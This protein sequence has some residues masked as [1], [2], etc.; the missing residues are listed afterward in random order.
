MRRFSFHRRGDVFYV[1][2]F[3]DATGRFGTAK[4]TGATNRDEAMIVAARWMTEGVP[5]GRRRTARPA[6][7][8]FTVEAILRAIKAPA[9]GDADAAL[10]LA[11][12]ES[13]GFVDK[14]ARRDSPAAVLVADF[15]R[16]FWDEDKSP[17]LREERARGRTITLRH[18]REMGRIVE[19]YWSDPFKGKRLGDLRKADIRGA[20][21]ALSEKGLAPGTI[22]KAFACLS[23]ALRWA[24]ESDV[25]EENPAQG[26]RKIVGK[27]KERGILE[28]EELRDLFALD[29]PDVRAKAAF[30]LAATTGMRRGEVMALQFRD[31]GADR[32]F[33]RHSWNDDDRLKT[34]KNGEE[35]E[36]VLLPAVREALVA[37]GEGN[38]F[39]T[40]PEVFVFYGAE[41]DRPLDGQI[42]S[43]AF[44]TALESIEIDDAARKARGLSFHSLRHGFAKRMA[45]RLDTERAMKA[46]GHLSRAMLE[47]YA[48]HRSKEDFAAVGTAAEEAFG[49]IL[50]FKKGA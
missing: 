34:P 47:H 40:G 33:V 30:M 2:L 36:A 8:A 44:E 26:V 24:A 16:T 35:R 15:L 45:D 41:P 13:R 29:W 31:I 23:T 11:A 3:N 17:Y 14:V 22:A 20:L 12:L 10:V 37:L 5:T 9:F 27:P 50:L 49:N 46:T 1:Q 48:D 4:S 43:R 7:E 28:D 42:V 38:P 32:I 21:V 19:R 6:A 39:G 25:I 18:V